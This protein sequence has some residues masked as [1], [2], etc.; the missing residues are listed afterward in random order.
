M[1]RYNTLSKNQNKNILKLIN[2]A[3]E[4]RRHINIIK[5]AIYC[6]KTRSSLNLYNLLLVFW[7]P[8]PQNQLTMT[9]RQ[10]NDNRNI[11]FFAE[12]LEKLVKIEKMFAL[13]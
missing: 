7:T 2:K 9:K 6:K 4:E 8:K 10:I 13:T 1:E 11:T 3:L 12:I 5:Y